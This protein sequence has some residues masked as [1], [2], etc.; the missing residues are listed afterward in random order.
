MRYAYKIV[1]GKPK[2]KIP[3]GT[4]RHRWEDNIK[5]VLGKQEC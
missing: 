3:L 2:K 4:P 5:M 1:A